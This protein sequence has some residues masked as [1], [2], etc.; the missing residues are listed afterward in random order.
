MV[1]SAALV[2]FQFQQTV[3][4]REL[5][6]VAVEITTHLGDQQTFFDGD[7][8]SFLLSLDRDCYV[9]LFYLDAGAK[10]IQIYP[11]QQS[12]S[13][14]YEK[15]IYMP[16]PPSKTGF[17]FKITPPFGREALFAF[18]SDNAEIK[19]EGRLLVNGLRLIDESFDDLQNRFRRQSSSVF[20]FSSLELVSR[21]R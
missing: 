3:T 12:G 11:N 13:H 14:F 6:P 18:A 5:A 7:V 2:V 8:I 21:S 1:V 10:L 19:L 4:A 15:G 9:Y 16:I 17:E 20:G